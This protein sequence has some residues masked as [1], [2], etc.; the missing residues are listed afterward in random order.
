MSGKPCKCPGTLDAHIVGCALRRQVNCGCTG[1]LCYRECQT[2]E[3]VLAGEA[4]SDRLNLLTEIH[5]FY[6]FAATDEEHFDS[7]LHEKIIAERERLGLPVADG[8]PTSAQQEDFDR[9]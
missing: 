5:E 8:S 1:G 7:W 9:G 6:E 3:P 2:R 4:S